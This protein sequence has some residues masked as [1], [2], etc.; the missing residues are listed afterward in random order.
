[1]IFKIPLIDP[2]DGL[3]ESSSAVG[4]ESLLIALDAFPAT[5]ASM[6]S[7]SS[8]EA[9]VF[10]CTVLRKGVLVS[11]RECT[12]WGTVGLSI[13]WSVLLGELVRSN[14]VGLSKN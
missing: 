5:L 11:L 8:E 7:P 1:M 10:S 12:L 3:R 14:N 2:D 9:N 4:D 13:F 6:S